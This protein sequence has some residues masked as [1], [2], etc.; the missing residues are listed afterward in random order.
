LIAVRLTLLQSSGSKV[1]S[2]KNITLLAQSTNYVFIKWHASIYKLC[3]N[4][5]LLQIA[6]KVNFANPIHQAPE[7]GLAA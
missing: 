7:G 2:L 5:D 1:E 4:I 3:I 6:V